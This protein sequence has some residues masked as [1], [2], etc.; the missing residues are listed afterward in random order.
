VKRFICTIYALVSLLVFFPVELRG[1]TPRKV[2][3]TIPVV[4]LSMTPVYLA[5]AKNFSL[6][7]G[8]M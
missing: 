2:K 4:A 8:W 6:K 3:L 5:Q 7:K 1:Q